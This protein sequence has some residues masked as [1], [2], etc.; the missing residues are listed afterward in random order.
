M[1]TETL[2]TFR[3]LFARL[4]G[5]G[6]PRPARRRGHGRRVYLEILEQ[7]CVTA[8]L[9]GVGLLAPGPFIGDV[10]ETTGP[11]GGD[12]DLLSKGAEADDLDVAPLHILIAPPGHS[13]PF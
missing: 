4:R 11:A 5:T 13:F 2:A 12:V 8:G 10:A 6:R 1:L 9:A 3:H 7:R